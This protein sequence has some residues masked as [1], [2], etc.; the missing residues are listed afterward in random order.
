MN[1]ETWIILIWYIPRF[2]FRLYS[3]LYAHKFHP[4]TAAADIAIRIFNSKIEKANSS[5]KSWILCW[6]G[7]PKI[8]I[9]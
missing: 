2:N 6:V 8:E 5:Q 3:V 4:T 1:F 7:S 9:V